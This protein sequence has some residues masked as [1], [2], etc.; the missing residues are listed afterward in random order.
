M[1]ENNIQT[2][3][4]PSGNAEGAVFITT[5]GAAW[6]YNGIMINAVVA[7]DNG[8]IYLAGYDR[9]K[10]GLVVLAYKDGSLNWSKT[11]REYSEGF[12][13]TFHDLAYKDGVVYAAGTISVEYEEDDFPNQETRPVKVDHKDFH[14]NYPK[15]ELYGFDPTYPI[16]VALDA[17]TG[18]A[19]NVQL[20]E[21]K[22][23]FGIDEIRSIQ[24]DSEGNVYVGGGGWNRGPDIT[25]PFYGAEFFWY[26]RKFNSSG[27]QLWETDAELVRVFE[28][29][30]AVEVLVTRGGGN[31]ALIDPITKVE[32]K[33]GIFSNAYS[34][35]EGVFGDWVRDIVADDHFIYILSARS[36]Q[37]YGEEQHGAVIKIDKATLLPVWEVEIGRDSAYLL[38]SD[39]E[40]DG[41]GNLLVVGESRGEVHGVAG[42]GGTDGFKLKIDSSTGILE[43]T[44]ILGTKLNESIAKIAYQAVLDDVGKAKLDSSGNPIKNLIIGGSFPV[45]K[46]SIEGKTE[47][48]IYLITNRGFEL[49][50][51]ALDNYIQGGGG[52]DKIFS[53]L[54][55][56]T[57]LSGSG[58]DLVYA[59][60]DNDLV[61]G[62]DGKG[63]DT[64]YGGKGVDTL[65]YTSATW[66]IKVDL[67]KG[68]VSSLENPSNKKNKDAANIGFDKVY[69]FEN[70]IGGNFDD[71]LIGNTQS[72]EIYGENGSDIIYGSGGTDALDGG[73]GSD[74]YLIA[75]ASE[76][77]SSEVISDTGDVGDR[78][79]IR[80]TA[81][82][83][84]TLVLN[85][86]TVGIERV[87]IGT[88]S[89]ETAVM[90]GK[91]ALNIDASAVKTALV[92]E[93]NA[94]ANKMTGTMGN[95]EIWGGVGNDILFGGAG[96]DSLFGGDGHD[97]LFGFLDYD[98]SSLSEK[99]FSDYVESQS[100]VH[101]HLYGGKGNDVYVFDK[102]V[103]IPN[104]IEYENEGIDTIIGDLAVYELP[105]HVENYVNDLFLTDNGLP[106]A[107][108]ITGNNLNNILKSSPSNWGKN[109]DIKTILATIDNSWASKEEFYGL[110]GNDTIMSGGGDDLLDGGEGADIMF[111]GAGN[112]KYIV[113]NPLD[114]VH[115][116]RS[117]KDKRDAGGIDTL[118][119]SIIY[120]LPSFVE[121][122]TL[123]GF[124]HLRGTGNSLNNHILGNSGNN[125][126]NG[127]AGADTMD[128]GDGSDVYL[129]ASASEHKFGEVI[130]D[131][132]T[133]AGDIDEIRYTSKKSGT[134]VLNDKT[135]G[136]ERVVIGTGSGETAV[137]T[138]KAAL[139]VD[140]SAVKT[141]LEMVGNAGAN[142]LI[143]T[144]ENDT[145]SGGVGKDTLTG[146][147]GDD[148]FVFDTLWG[149]GNI[150]TI[151]DFGLGADKIILDKSIFKKF[152]LMDGVLEGNIYDSS[153]DEPRGINHY[154]IFV[155][156]DKSSALYYDTDEAGKAGMVQF[157]TLVG[158]S[159]ISHEDF[160]II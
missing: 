93:G 123:T 122:L 118:E 37:P 109:W 154:L 92:M 139:N 77:T 4:Q 135:E 35:S 102:Y 14:D 157:V 147:L 66:G 78:D 84:G 126:L 53:G 82:K 117:S 85:D 97:W 125:V 20:L 46:Y 3:N 47:K 49:I 19:I 69:Q 72:N 18:D 91:A 7:G 150:D 43:S 99:D 52:S 13:S 141:S 23:V 32:L 113:D 90:T 89:G 104:V 86:K 158:V 60:D 148:H 96:E 40:F 34:E 5:L 124:E 41:Q 29:D 146:G 27:E 74:V 58:N 55:A 10:S 100:S 88:G 26:V 65:K 50:G 44:E 159:E 81:A 42:F 143:G 15:R 129:I 45:A 54:G 8:W 105:D 103:G 28:V 132:G 137:T 1:I 94:G 134:L 75:Q 73:E 51:N 16:Y 153:M 22:N 101:D 95:D 71:V 142:K 64:Y 2:M 80:Y 128:G 83:A 36:K 70:I 131:T 24:A 144:Q 156:G 33:S 68:S 9:G 38:P 76:H 63:N 39:F 120:T 67:T 61:I 130:A 160:L 25:N 57:I 114:Q 110:G 116:F 121:N 17:D 136:I 31:I 151:T 21:S 56:D 59:G 145:I 12:A 30:D 140:A 62:G 149:K 133:A 119:A 115:E 6:T 108:E 11:F 106:V 98:D 87:V 152:E 127:M 111:G 79:E 112:D 138:G 48:D 155:K 107:I